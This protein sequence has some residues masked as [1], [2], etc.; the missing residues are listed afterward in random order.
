MLKMYRYYIS[1]VH[2]DN[3]ISYISTQVCILS[4]YSKNVFFV[5]IVYTTIM[6]WD[7]YLHKF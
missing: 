1:G 4:S 6:N 7:I 3:Y 2:I 5:C